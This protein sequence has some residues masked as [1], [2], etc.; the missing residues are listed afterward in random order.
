MK[1]NNFIEDRKQHINNTKKSMFNQLY[2]KHLNGNSISENEC[3]YY[4]NINTTL[5]HMTSN[6]EIC[7]INSIYNEFNSF[8]LKK[9]EDLIDSGII[10]INYFDLL[11]QYAKTVIFTKNNKFTDKYCAQYKFYN[12]TVKNDHIITIQ[13]SIDIDQELSMFRNCQFIRHTRFTIWLNWTQRQYDF[14]WKTL[15]K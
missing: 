4:F 3:F 12:P 1:E 8:V 14:I 15:K 13:H 7:G 2:L 10:L 11:N 9:L 6:Y 5:L